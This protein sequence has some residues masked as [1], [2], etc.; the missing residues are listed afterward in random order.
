MKANGMARLA[1]AA[2]TLLTLSS[3]GAYAESCDSSWYARN[4]IYKAGGYCFH[5]ARGIQAFGNAGCQY[6]DVNEVPLSEQ[7][8]RII[9]DIAR[10][11]RIHGCR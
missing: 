1:I 7:Q 11:E 4:E 2:I 6:D 3:A 5:T 9:A 8:R 10:Q